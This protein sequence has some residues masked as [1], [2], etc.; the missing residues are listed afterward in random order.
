[1]PNPSLGAICRQVCGL[2]DPLTDREPE[3]DGSKLACLCIA[4]AALGITSVVVGL[5]GAMAVCE[6]VIY[7][8]EVKLTPM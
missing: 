6:D 4:I 5:V 2:N 1:V 8:I 7:V 3:S